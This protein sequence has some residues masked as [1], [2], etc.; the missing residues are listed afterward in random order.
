MTAAAIAAQLVDMRNVGAHKSLRLTIHVPQEQALAAIAAFGWPTGA[1]P[2]PVAIARMNSGTPLHPAE[3]SQPGDSGAP[4][5]SRTSDV[6]AGRDRQPVRFDEM[7]M[8]AQA[9]MLSHNP[10]F[11]AFMNERY[12]A[13]IGPDDVDGVAVYIRWLFG[14]TSRSQIL[15][16]NYAGHG[17]QELVKEYRTWQ[18]APKVGAT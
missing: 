11:R 8:A 14:V 15:P 13:D 17:W 6:T 9:G 4:T 7:S 10:Q 12:Q 2:V 1:D 5:S 3:H 18:L 16:T